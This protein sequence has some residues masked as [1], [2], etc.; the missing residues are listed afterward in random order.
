MNNNRLEMVTLAGPQGMAV[1]HDGECWR[2][3]YDWII[4]D[5]ILATGEAHII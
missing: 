4:F 2:R 3:L 1:I 5:I